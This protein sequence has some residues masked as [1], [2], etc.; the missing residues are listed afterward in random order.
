MSRSPIFYLLMFPV[1]SMEISYLELCSHLFSKVFL[2]YLLQG[3]CWLLGSS[4]E[5]DRHKLTI[6]GE[7]DV[8]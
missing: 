6:L 1:P 3:V 5:Q 7:G 2:G 8:K 4:P